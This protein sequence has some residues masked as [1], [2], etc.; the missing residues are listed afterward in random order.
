LYGENGAVVVL[1]VR[2]GHILYIL[3]FERKGMGECRRQCLVKSRGDN[4][5]FM[6]AGVCVCVLFSLLDANGA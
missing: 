4:R 6:R 3:K 1:V 2:H 5:D